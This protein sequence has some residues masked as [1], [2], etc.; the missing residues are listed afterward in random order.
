[1][2]I[3]LRLAARP[4]AERTCRTWRSTPQFAS[5]P[6]W[7]AWSAAPAQLAGA[8]ISAQAWRWSQRTTRKTRSRLQSAPCRSRKSPPDLII[9]C[10]DNCT[11]RRAPRAEAAGAHVFETVENVH[12]KAG[13]LNQ[14]L[15]ILLPELHDEDAVLVMDADSALAPRF[16]AEAMRRLREGVGGVGCVVGALQEHILASDRWEN[17]EGT[18]RISG[19]GEYLAVHLPGIFVGIEKDGYLLVA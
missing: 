1:M 12:R 10:A 3:R 8:Q 18:L 4:F 2:L 9:V 16:L 6:P 13:A 17:V 15:D 5:K 7:Q 14:V 19:H 11:D